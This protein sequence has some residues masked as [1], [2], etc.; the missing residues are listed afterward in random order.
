[1]IK[2]VNEILAASGGVFAGGAAMKLMKSADGKTNPIAALGSAALGTYLVIKGKTPIVK[3]MGLGLAAVGVVGTLGKIAEKVPAL[4][5]F[6]PSINGI[7][8]L[9]EDENGNIVELGSL[10]GGPQMVQ[11]ENGQTYMIEGLAGDEMDDLVG[12]YGDDEF[13]DLDGLAGDDLRALVA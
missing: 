3:A 12:L 1:M 7:G 13:E 11:D 4:G 8:E 6:T 10:A 9:Y 5:K 2:N